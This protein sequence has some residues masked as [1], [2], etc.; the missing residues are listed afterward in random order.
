MEKTTFTQEEISKIKQ[1]QEK[2]Q[3][4]GIQVVQLTLAKKSTQEYLQSLEDQNN[5]LTNQI[6]EVNI[7]EKEFAKTL[8]DKYGIGSLDLESGVFTSNT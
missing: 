7:E 6:I 8:S 4:L 2:Y 3:V 1:L 5:R